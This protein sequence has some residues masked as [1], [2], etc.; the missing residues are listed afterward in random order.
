M[1]LVTREGQ[2]Y[3]DITKLD[4]LSHIVKFTCNNERLHIPYSNISYIKK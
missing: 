3:N 4:E 1:K 2:I